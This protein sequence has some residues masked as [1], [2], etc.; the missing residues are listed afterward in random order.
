MEMRSNHSH[1]CEFVPNMSMRC[2]SFERKRIRESGEQNDCFITE[3]IDNIFKKMFYAVIFRD[4][5]HIVILLLSSFVGTV[6]KKQKK[7]QKRSFV[8]MTV[9]V[10]DIITMNLFG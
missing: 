6:V 8:L 4:L 1:F 7:K 10:L 3:W 2:V 5:V 9:Q